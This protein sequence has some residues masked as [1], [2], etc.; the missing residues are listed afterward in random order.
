MYAALCSDRRASD[1]IFRGQKYNLLSRKQLSHFRPLD[2]SKTKNRKDLTARS[3]IGRYCTTIKWKCYSTLKEDLGRIALTSAFP[4]LSRRTRRRRRERPKNA[5]GRAIAGCER[6]TDTE[7][8]RHL[9]PKEDKMLIKK[10]NE[11]LKSVW[12]VPNLYLLFIKPQYIVYKIKIPAWKRG[13][14]HFRV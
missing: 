12:F 13:V 11:A 14:F 6:R 2:Y 10:L 5:R 3:F 7:H 4:R 8:L 1:C 9:M